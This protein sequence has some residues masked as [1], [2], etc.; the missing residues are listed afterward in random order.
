MAKSLEGVGADL[1]GVKAKSLIGVVSEEASATNDRLTAQYAQADFGMH[2]N[3]IRKGVISNVNEETG[4]GTR[5]G[6]T[7]NDIK[8]EIHVPP[9]TDAETARRAGAAAKE[10]VSKGL[11]EA[12]R[13]KLQAALV[14]GKG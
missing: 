14:Q 9:G 1:E 2:N 6:A 3:A 7:N 8:V 5:E 12:E 13:R 11:D 10:G 4:T